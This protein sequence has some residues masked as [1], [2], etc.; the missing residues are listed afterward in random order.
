MFQASLLYVADSSVRTAAVR[1]YVA[2]VCDND[3]EEKVIRSLSDLIPSVIQVG[4]FCLL[5]NLCTKNFLGLP[6]CCFNRG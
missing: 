2:F 1:A 3:E 6:T 5:E 4:N